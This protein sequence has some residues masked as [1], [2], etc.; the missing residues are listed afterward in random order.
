MYREAMVAVSYVQ[1]EAEHIEEA[2][3][4]AAALH[5]KDCCTEKCA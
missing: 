4:G 5:D 1:R 3:T 2:E